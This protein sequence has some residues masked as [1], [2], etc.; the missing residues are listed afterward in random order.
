[1]KDLKLT[2]KIENNKLPNFQLSIGRAIR[3]CGGIDRWVWEVFDM[4]GFGRQG[5]K[6][7]I[8]IAIAKNFK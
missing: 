1:M 7:K 4:Q 2:R 5:I 8:Q 3:L 6:K